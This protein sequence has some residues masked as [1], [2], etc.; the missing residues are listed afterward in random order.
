MIVVDPR[1]QPLA[2]IDKLATARRFRPYAGWHGDY[3][4][5]T[6]GQMRSAEYRPVFQQNREEFLALCELLIRRNLRGRALQ[7][8]L[9]RP[10][11]THAAFSLLFGEVWTIEHDAA[12]VAA[13]PRRW[14]E[15]PHF[16]VGDS[17][18][19][20]TLE[21]AVE[22]APYDFVFLDG[23]HRLPGVRHDFHDYRQLVRP[24]GIIALHDALK[25]PGY[26]NEIQTWR[27]VAGRPFN[28]IGS[29]L[30]IAWTE[31]V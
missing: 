26:E 7:I 21:S 2:D 22:H 24:G 29:K 19:A 30:G 14:L 5:L 4:G 25:R 8:G 9:G 17:H 3:R 18:S 13:Y 10:G 20:A 23:D 6:P 27:L 11:G 28:M 12:T 1:W 16:I 15:R 31:K